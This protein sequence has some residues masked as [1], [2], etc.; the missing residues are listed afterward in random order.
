MHPTVDLLA[1]AEGEPDPLAAAHV[2]ACADCRRIVEEIRAS[3]ALMRRAPA[4]EVPAFERVAN[5]VRARSR[6][7]VWRAFAAAASLLVTS[8]VFL[9]RPAPRLDLVVRDVTPDDDR[10]A[11]ASLGGPFG[12]LADVPDEEM[13]P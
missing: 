3:I 5:A 10:G 13:H 1:Y 12:A 6:R 8:A 2:A 4:G 7:R 11:F 9:L